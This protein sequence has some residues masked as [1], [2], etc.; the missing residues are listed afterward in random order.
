MNWSHVAGLE[1]V[2]AVYG[3]PL[4][5]EERIEAGEW[6]AV[7]AGWVLVIWSTVLVNDG[8]LRLDGVVRVGREPDQ[9]RGGVALV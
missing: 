3:P 6:C 4:R 5:A 2:A 1:R 8:V 9:A 7:F